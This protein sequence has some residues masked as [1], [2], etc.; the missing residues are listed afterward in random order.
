MI[1]YFLGSEASSMAHSSLDIRPISQGRETGTE[2]LSL[3]M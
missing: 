3:P 2:E 1:A